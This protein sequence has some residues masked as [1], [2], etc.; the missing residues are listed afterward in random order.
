MLRPGP[1]SATRSERILCPPPLRLIVPRSEVAKE[2]GPGE[3][4]VAFGGATGDPERLGGLVDRQAREEAELDERR[5]ACVDG[6]EAG[7]RLVQVDQ[8]VGRGVL[9]PQRLEVE[10]LV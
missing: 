9:A 2:P 1:R 8:V 7:D 4:P 3:G 5:R 6:G 10:I